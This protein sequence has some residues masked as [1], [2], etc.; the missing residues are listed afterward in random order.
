[1]SKPNEVPRWVEASDYEEWLYELSQRHQDMVLSDNP[2]V[3]GEQY[4]VVSEQEKDPL[5]NPETP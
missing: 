3:A 2:Q 1:M 4:R 5:G